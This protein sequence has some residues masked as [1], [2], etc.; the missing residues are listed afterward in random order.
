MSADCLPKK[1]PSLDVFLFSFVEQREPMRGGGGQPKIG[2]LTVGLSVWLTSLD[3]TKVTQRHRLQRPRW[4]FAGSIA[5]PLGSFARVTFSK[6][7]R[8][9]LTLQWH[10]FYFLPSSLSMHLEN[11]IRGY[12]YCN[13]NALH[14]GTKPTVLF[15][16]FVNEFQFTFEKDRV[17]S[18]VVTDQDAIPFFI[19]LT[20]N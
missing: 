12:L 9:L 18:P 17:S 15:W 6:G 13:T 3:H 4:H 20:G 2:C 19:K 16:R 1:Q 7:L 5:I 14:C 10:F 8:Y 11:Q